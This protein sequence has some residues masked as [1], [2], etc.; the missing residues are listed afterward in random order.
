M[1]KLKGLDEKHFEFGRFIESEVFG[2]S[3]DWLKSHITVSKVKVFEIIAAIRSNA[4]LPDYK[5]N[6][7]ARTAER[8]GAP[9]LFGFDMQVELE[10]F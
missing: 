1:A 5:E 6:F 8:A 9:F 2:K 10:V 3:I 7:M 4:R